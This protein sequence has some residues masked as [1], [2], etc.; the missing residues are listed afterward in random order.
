[1][2]S[3]SFLALALAAALLLSG[4]VGSGPSQALAQ[5]CVSQSEARAAVASGQA[6]P[7]SQFSGRLRSMGDVV[8]SCLVDQGGGSYAYVGS[9]LQA[10]GQVTKF[11][12]NAK[13]GQ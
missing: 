10:N 8:S 7:F 13:S 5:G 6:R 3:N 2:A 4:P 11:A 12:I 9:I 1:M